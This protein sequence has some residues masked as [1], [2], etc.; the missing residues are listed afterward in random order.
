MYE[1][2]RDH[3]TCESVQPQ[4][5]GNIA[6]SQQPPTASKG[7]TLPQKAE[8]EPRKQVTLRAQLTTNRLLGQREQE[9]QERKGKGAR[10]EH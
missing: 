9:E 10:A 7:S 5:M 2:P 8:E 1:T 3:A 4:S 6:A